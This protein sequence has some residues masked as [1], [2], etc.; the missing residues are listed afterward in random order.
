MEQ[1]GCTRGLENG[2]DTGTM[3]AHKKGH[4]KEYGNYTV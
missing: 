2:D 4:T 3:P 1:R